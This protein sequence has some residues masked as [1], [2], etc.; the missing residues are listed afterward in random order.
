MRLVIK[1]MIRRICR[2]FCKHQ[3]VFI[4]NPGIVR[5]YRD[6]VDMGIM[7]HGA[8]LVC[9]MDC[10]KVVASNYAE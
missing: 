4:V 5:W 8:K 3:R 10:G 2:I 6:G 1:R 7:T 9:C